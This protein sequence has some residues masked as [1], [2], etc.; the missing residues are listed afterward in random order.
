MELTPTIEHQYDPSSVDPRTIKSYRY[1]AALKKWL[2]QLDSAKQLDTIVGCS[3]NYRVLEEKFN[4]NYVSIICKFT[5][6]SELDRFEE[7]FLNGCLKQLLE[8]YFTKTDLLLEH[9]EGTRTS[10]KEF[11][12]E[13]DLTEIKKCISESYRA[14]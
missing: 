13:V 1:S 8:Q 14:R 4:C 9:G 11:R 5:K 10:S 2:L 3:F 12:L 6:E 7:L